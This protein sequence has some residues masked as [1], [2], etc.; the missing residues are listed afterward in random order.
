MIIV[1][2]SICPLLF[3]LQMCCY[4]RRTRRSKFEK[5]HKLF[6]YNQQQRMFNETDGNILIHEY[7]QLF[8]F[9]TEHTYSH[10]LPFATL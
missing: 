10:L 5:L 7:T 9:M 8:E 3:H 6:V 2:M 1:Q 4:K